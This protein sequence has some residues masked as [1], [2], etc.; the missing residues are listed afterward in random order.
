MGRVSPESKLCE[1]RCEANMWVAGVLFGVIF[2][3]ISSQ[4]VVEGRLDYIKTKSGWTNPSASKDQLL[5]RS[6]RR[7][8]LGRYKRSDNVPVASL[9]FILD[10]DSHRYARVH[11]SGEDSDVSTISVAV[12]G[13]LMCGSSSS[14]SSSVVRKCFRRLIHVFT[15]CCTLL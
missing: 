10:G 5:F 6:P 1:A 9:P 15:L 12:Y 8:D 4:C 3:A 13:Y 14:S 7:T 2:V 11:Y